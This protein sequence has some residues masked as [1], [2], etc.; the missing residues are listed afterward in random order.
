MPVALPRIVDGVHHKAVDIGDG[1][2]IRF[3]GVADGLF[4]FVEQEGRPGVR[5]VG[6]DLDAL[7]AESG[8]TAHRLRKGIIQI[9]IRAESEFHY[10]TQKLTT[11][12]QRHREEKRKNQFSFFSSL[13]LCVSVVR[14][15]S[16]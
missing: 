16:T 1:Q 5:H 10:T 7:V 12:R 15:S 11:E 14:N 9:R 4:L 13:C 3:Q 2:T 8:E 6:H